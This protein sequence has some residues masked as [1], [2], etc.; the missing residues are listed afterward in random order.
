MSTRIV[1]TD[2]CKGLC[3]IVGRT[4]RI[5]ER[6]EIV[7]TNDNEYDCDGLVKVYNSVTNKLIYSSSVK[8]LR[9]YVYSHIFRCGICRKIYKEQLGVIAP[10][11]DKMEIYYY[12]PTCYFCG[13]EAVYKA[14]D[15]RWDMMFIMWLCKEHKEKWVHRT[16]TDEE[17]A[18]IDA[19]YD[20]MERKKA[21]QE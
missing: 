2:K 16:F 14:Q 17:W 20:E 13:K 9:Y 3:E 12:K 21:E 6:I 10:M 11:I 8:G 15:C 7:A 19:V 1:I 18:K 4:P 5:Y